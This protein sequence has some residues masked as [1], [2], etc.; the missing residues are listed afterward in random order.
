[1]GRAQTIKEQQ[2]KGEEDKLILA[3]FVHGGLQ[4]AEDRHTVSVQRAKLT[5][6]IGRLHLQRA[7]RLDRAPVAVRPVEAGTGE[8][9]DLVAVDPGMY[10]VAVV[11]DL[12]KPAVARW[13]LVNQARELRLDPLW[14]P[15]CRSHQT[16]LRQ[17]L[18]VQ[19][20]QRFDVWAGHRGLRV[21]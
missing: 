5:V 9:L 11:L 21:N 13:R 17:A 18:D 12:V 2:V 1:M 7:D 10:S 14:R 15:R 19:A 8:Q 6:E 3:A 20:V 4:P 16:S